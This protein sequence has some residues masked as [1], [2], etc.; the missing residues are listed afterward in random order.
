MIEIKKGSQILKVSKCAYKDTF[1]KLG[2]KIVDNS[3]EE[4]KQASSDD[5][6]KTIDSQDEKL[7]DDEKENN[8]KIEKDLDV[9]TSNSLNVNIIGE[10]INN[11]G[12]E[13]DKVEA[14][15]D[16]NEPKQSILEKALE[17]KNNKPK[18]K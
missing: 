9:V 10:N 7:I 2:Y 3:K 4:A 1:K 12:N 5:S 11:F 16:E 17:G 13:T 15:E 14:K 6:Q 18:G 8:E